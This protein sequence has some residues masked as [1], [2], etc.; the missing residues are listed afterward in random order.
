[1]FICSTQL[2]DLKH[3]S[4]VIVAQQVKTILYFDSLYRLKEP[5]ELFNVNSTFDI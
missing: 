2:K 3:R 5:V 1:M 4:L